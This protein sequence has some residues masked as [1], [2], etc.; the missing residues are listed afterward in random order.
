MSPP[1]EVPSETSPLLGRQSNG[2]VSSKSLSGGT[3]TGINIGDGDADIG[4]DLERHDSIDESRAAQF[5][6]RP[7]VMKQLKYIVPAL[8]VGV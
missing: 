6:G 1:D 4:P 7:E 8:S 2:D 3:A 5:Q